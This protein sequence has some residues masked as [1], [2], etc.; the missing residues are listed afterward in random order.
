[1]FVA[2]GMANPIENKRNNTFPVTFIILAIPKAAKLAKSKVIVTEKPVTIKLFKKF[3]S[4]ALS[5][6]SL[7]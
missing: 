3:C 5:V 4:M 6:K 2:A 1:M 7:L